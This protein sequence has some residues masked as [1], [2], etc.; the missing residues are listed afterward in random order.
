[1]ERY[2]D[3][4]K[5]CGADIWFIKEKSVYSNE[6]FFI[7]KKLD[8]RRINNSKDSVITVYCDKEIDGK[9]YEPIE[10]VYIEC[11]EMFT[12][13]VTEKLSARKGRMTVTEV[14]W[15]IDVTAPCRTLVS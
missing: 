2:I 6:L 5:S 15:A 12:G 10:H 13:I 8:M 7:K 3:L 14:A 4:L 11:H 9:K 1:M